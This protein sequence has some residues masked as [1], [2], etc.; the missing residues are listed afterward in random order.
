MWNIGLNTWQDT[1]VSQL[2]DMT[3]ACVISKCF[4]ESDGSYEKVCFQSALQAHL[5]KY[6]K[7]VVKNACLKINI[8]GKSIWNV[9]TL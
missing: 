5:E 8:K 9:G 3:D 4:L 1:V 6:E 2:Q 7:L